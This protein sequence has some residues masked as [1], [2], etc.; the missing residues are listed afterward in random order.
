MLSAQELDCLLIQVSKKDMK[1]FEKFY[2]EMNKAVYGLAYALTKSSHDAEDVMQNTFI[3]VWE[4]AYLYH[5]GTNA[6]AWTMKIAR[7]FSL[8]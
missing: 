7:N 5:N 4:K 2:Q 6:K 8:T 3:K 1:A